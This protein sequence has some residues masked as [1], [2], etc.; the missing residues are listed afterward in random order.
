MTTPI[1]PAT[2]RTK[3]LASSIANLLDALP[4]F[5]TWKEASKILGKIVEQ[6]INSHDGIE[7]E[8]GEAIIQRTQSDDALIQKC[9]ELLAKEN[10]VRLLEQERGQLKAELEKSDKI[11]NE[12]ADK[13][14]DSEMRENDLK[15]EVERLK[16][17]AR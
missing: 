10:N 15:A 13:L 14:V 3:E 4:E 7:T 12:L 5:I 8:L 17:S 16:Q 11:Q 2:P 1:K 9:L 6:C